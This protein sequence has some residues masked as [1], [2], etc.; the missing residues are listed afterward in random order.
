MIPLG[1]FFPLHCI[2]LIKSCDKSTNSASSAEVIL[3]PFLYFIILFIIVSY[4]SELFYTINE[5]YIDYLSKFDSHVSWNKEQKRPYIGIAYD[6]P[7]RFQKLDKNE[8]APLYEWKMTE[9][10]CLQYTKKKG[11]Y[12]PLYDKF[13]RLGCWFCIKQSLNDLRILRKDYPELWKMLL[14]WQLD[15][16]VK[17]RTDYS[18]QELEEKFKKEECRLKI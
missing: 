12:N 10:D 16:A 8:K 3:L 11:L 13:N 2:C 7:K 15:S 1:V 5:D 14:N 18:V 9:L 17:F 6:E 4:I